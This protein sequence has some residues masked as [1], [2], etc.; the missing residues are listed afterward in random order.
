MTFGDFDV[1]VQKVATSL[2]Q[3]G[4]SKG[5]VVLTNMINC[6]EYPILYHAL[7]ALG[8]VLSPAAPTFSATELGHQLVASNASFLVSH[9]SVEAIAAEVAVA[10]NIPSDR[11]FSVGPTTMMQKFRDLLQVDAIHIPHV[12]IDHASDINTLPYSSG[13]TGRPKGVKL[14]FAN[15][16]INIQQMAFMEPMTS[17]LVLALPMYHLYAGLLMNAALLCGQ[18]LV[19]LPKFDLATFLQALQV[20]KSEKAFIVPPIATLMATHPLVDEYDLSATK[21]FVSAAAPLGPTLE[22]AVQARLGIKTKQAYGMT[23]LSP[24]VHYTRDGHERP[25]ASGHLVPNTELRVVCPTTGADLGPH[26][27]GELWYRGPQVMLGYLNNDD[28]TRV[29]KSKR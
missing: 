25:A 3:R 28:A 9:A 15:L 29:R 14:S 12:V 10:H 7:T 8:A 18:P 2:A 1:A 4:V 23:E 13:T 19:V 6:V 20:H 27:I 21:Y 22:A 17:P 24:L 16:A 5:R 26:Q 11:C